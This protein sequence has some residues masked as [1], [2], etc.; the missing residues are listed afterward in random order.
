MQSTDWTLCILCQTETNEA[1]QCPAESCCKDV[2]IDYSTFS[3]NLQKFPELQELPMDKNINR[4]N[5]GGG[6][7][8]TLEHNKAKWHKSCHIKF[9]SPKLKRAEKRKS[10]TNIGI[11]ASSKKFTQ[12]SEQHSRIEKD[13]FFCVISVH[14]RQSTLLAPFKLM[15][16]C[17][18]P[19]R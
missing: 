2:V 8:S 16:M 3:E 5:E 18:G 15:L 19:T 11:A 7:V 12:N 13:V 6:I 14:Q 17:N 1:L 10:E 9:N 4:L